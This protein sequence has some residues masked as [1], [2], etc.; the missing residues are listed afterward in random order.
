MHYILTS[1][2]YLDYIAFVNNIIRTNILTINTVND[3]GCKFNVSRM[4]VSTCKKGFLK[5]RG[6]IG[7]AGKTGT[8]SAI[9][10]KEE[11]MNKGTQNA[12]GKSQRNEPSPI[13]RTQKAS[14]QMGTLNVTPQP[15][16]GGGRQQKNSNEHIALV[17]QETAI[18]LTRKLT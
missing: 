12:P 15:S 6:Q 17:L 10:G 9:S 5:N 16:K 2:S 1:K 3:T 8:A 18:K 14:R 11:P 7:D 4:K 13:N